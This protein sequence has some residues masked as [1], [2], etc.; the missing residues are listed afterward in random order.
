MTCAGEL[1]N[2][3]SIVRALGGADLIDVDS[4]ISLEGP[5][6]LGRGGRSS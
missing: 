5:Q 6:P 2:A 4:L 3:I 1:R